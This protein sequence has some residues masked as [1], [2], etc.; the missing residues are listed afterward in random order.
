MIQL[1]NLS[2]SRGQNPGHR[3]SPGGCSLYITVVRN[4]TSYCVSRD[5]L[6]NFI[7]DFET[8]TVHDFD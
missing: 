3:F 5:D 4:P 7:S 6:D 8:N 1:V 2:Q